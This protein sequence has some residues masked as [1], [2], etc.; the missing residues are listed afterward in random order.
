MTTTGLEL[1]LWAAG[2][3]VNGAL[4]CV[5]LLRGRAAHFPWFT[6]LI[7][8]NVLRSPILFYVRNYGSVRAY[9]LSYWTLAILCD[10]VVQSGVVYELATH[11]FR[12]LG[13][14]AADTRR[15]M[16]WLV[17]ISFAVAGLL[18]W[19]A[20]PVS[21]AWQEAVVVKGSFFFTTLMSELFVGMVSLSVTA[22]LP[23]RTHV[24]RIAQGLGVYSLL[25]IAIEAA[26]T[27]YGAQYRTHTDVLLSD[28]RKLLYL[29]SVVYWIFA[30]WQDA[31]EPRE[32]P[33]EVRKHLRELQTRLTYDLYTLRGGKKL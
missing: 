22:G 21:D 28:T 5:L 19:L 29:G 16:G 6:T 17:L 13:R 30:L 4:L 24:A 31:P 10:V 33:A 23:W 9:F 2:L 26:H 32:L 12:P 8:G 18:T 1:F 25:D 11:V 27:L 15:G 3:L 20:T 14:W 7:V